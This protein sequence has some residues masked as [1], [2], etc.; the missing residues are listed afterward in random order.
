MEES[1]E[2]DT[3]PLANSIHGMSTPHGDPE[4]IPVTF[5]GEVLDD[6]VDSGVFSNRNNDAGSFDLGS[7]ADSKAQPPPH[8]AE[9]PQ[10]HSQRRAAGPSSPAPSREPER[11]VRSA[12]T[13]T[14][15]EVDPRK[16]E[17]TASSASALHT[18]HWNGKEEGRAPVSA[19]S[20]GTPAPGRVI[21]QLGKEKASDGK[22]DISTLPPWHQ[23]GQHPAGSYGL[24]YGLTTYKIV[25]PKSEMKC[26]DRGASLSVGAIK[27]D[28]LGNLVSPHVHTGRTVVPS[29]PTLEAETPPIGKVKEFWRSNSIEKH[30][31]RPMERPKRT[32]TPTTPTN[33]QPQESR[34]RGEPTSPDP[35]GT[36]PGPQS[37][38]SED[39][40]AVGEGRSWPPPAATRPL[41]VPA[42]NPAEVP[43]LKPQRRTSSQYMA[44]AIAKRIGTPK[45]HSDAGRRQ[46]NTQRT[47]EGTAPEPV[48]A[49]PVVKDSTTPSPNPGTGIRRE[50]EESTAGPHPGWQ[51][52][53]PYRKLS[54]QDYRSG[55]HRN[56]H[57]SLVTAAQRDQA[58]V[59]Q[60]SGLSGEQNIRTH[61]TDSASDPKYKSDGLSPS[62]LHSGDDQTSG[63]T[64][65]NGS[66][67]VPIHSEPPCSPRVSD[68]N[69]RAGQEPPQ[70]EEKPSLLS[71]GALE[72]DG[73][74]PASIFGPKKKFRPVV[75]RPAPK[76]TSLHSALMEAIHSAGGKDRLRKVKLLVG[77]CL[78]DGL[79]PTPTQTQILGD[80]RGGGPG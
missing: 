50:G 45:V 30:S 61:R 64:L 19:H 21:P 34:L 33:L 80:I 69:G 4:A 7:T 59:G 31:G 9:C 26:Y 12:L 5:I 32:P 63:S 77:F 49:P 47:Y 74:L 36:L 39:G 10:Q 57:G 58:S 23:R 1:Y 55:I 25:P 68:T 72:A 24:K 48:V 60:S 75:Q 67:W 35:Q 44:S 6:P 40:R 38:H 46:D 52:S 51:V 18:H 62:R 73:T 71:T 14:W 79:S 54:A 3:G 42:A 70:R 17:P 29:S 2:A 53:S 28:E 56:S 16:M 66:R 20:G 78:R 15:K 13:N 41:Q 27:I 37:P 65:V 76:D 8:Q 43:F 11:E 22:G